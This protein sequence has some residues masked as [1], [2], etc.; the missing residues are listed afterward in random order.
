MLLIITGKSDGTVDALVDYL[1]NPFFRLNLD[2]F[3]KYQFD[4]SSEY[5]SITNPVGLEIDSKNASACFWWKAFMYQLDPDLYVRDEIK[6]IAESLYSWFITR[7]M[8]K[9]NPPY[10]ESSWGKLRQ[11]DIA[12]KYLKVPPQKVGWGEDFLAS[13]DSNSNWVAKSLSGTLINS[14]KALFTTDVSPAELDPSYPWYIQEKIESDSDITVLAAGQNLHAFEKSRADLSGIDWRQEQ[15]RSKTAW[16]P[17]DLPS[18]EQ[19]AIWAFLKEM[20][21]NWG[22][23]DFM[24]NETGLQFLEL[25]PNGQWVF[26]DPRNEFGLLS[27]VAEYLEAPFREEV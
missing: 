12:R 4:F 14:E 2:D 8:T 7:N 18:Q 11:G 16:K 17:I 23:M 3:R 19:N 9:G 20:E 6:L 24:R 27:A 1:K 10:L 22:R 5:W 21:V 15:F 13:F 25:N 26:L